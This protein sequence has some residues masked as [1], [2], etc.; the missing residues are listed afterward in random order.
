MADEETRNMADEETRYIVVDGRRWRATDPS[1]PEELKAR[2][3]SGLMRARRAVRHHAGDRE[4]VG[5]ARRCVHDAKVALGERGHPWW[6]PSSPESRR[7]RIE[8]TIR[9]LLRS[10]D[11]GVTVSPSDIARVVGQPEWREAMGEVRAIAA[12]LAGRLVVE[13]T[14]HDDTVTDP[15][16]PGP[17]RY[18]AGPN[19]EDPV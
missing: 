8:A 12:E 17:V 16:T 18:R 13:P 10:P 6:E 4:A 2:L 9:T 15:G 5:R 14:N 11:P 1:I 3:V 19:L 7:D